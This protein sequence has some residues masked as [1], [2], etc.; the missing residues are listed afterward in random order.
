[1]PIQFPER[2]ETDEQARARKEKIKEHNEAYGCDIHGRP[3]SEEEKLLKNF[4]EK[5]WELFRKFK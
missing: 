4:R 5:D 2:R 1:M 3:V